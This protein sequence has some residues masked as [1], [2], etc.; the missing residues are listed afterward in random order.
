MK[1]ILHSIAVLGM[2]C[3]LMS[4]VWALGPCPESIT[5]ERDI[6]QGAGLNK[7]ITDKNM[8]GYVSISPSAI[9]IT[10]HF[11][12]LLVFN[13]EIKKGSE[14]D[15]K[16][17]NID[18][19]GDLSCGYIPK[20]EG[21]VLT[22][23]TKNRYF[24]PL[25]PIQKTDPRTT[26]NTPTWVGPSP[27]YLFA[28]LGYSCVKENGASQCKVEA[29]PSQAGGTCYNVAIVWTDGPQ[30][31][32]KDYM[33]GETFDTSNNCPE[34]ASFSPYGPCGGP[35]NSHHCAYDNESKHK[36]GINLP[37]DGT[38]P[39]NIVAET[40]V[41]THYSRV[42]KPNCPFPGCGQTCYQGPC[43][44]YGQKRIITSFSGKKTEI[45]E[46]DTGTFDHFK[47]NTT[48]IHIMTDLN[49]TSGVNK[50]TPVPPRTGGG[51]LE[52]SALWLSVSGHDKDNIIAT[53]TNIDK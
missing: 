38:H 44:I 27:A 45:S 3:V 42:C 26:P 14:F 40:P 2:S 5:T 32:F 15:I 50:Y 37:Y 7:T 39:I 21:L 12:S 9:N 46:D 29:E 17:E 48:S 31:D 22:I 43:D 20:D 6:L 8:N 1:K 16:Y 10:W 49:S 24:T 23:T 34:K 25:K 51:L 19:N 47:L 30:N 53:L 33:G 11:Q 41:C 52:G 13:K 36:W 35:G 18:P 4:T 28:P